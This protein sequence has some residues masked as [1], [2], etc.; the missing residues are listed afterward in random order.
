MSVVKS[1]SGGTFVPGTGI[2]A[3]CPRNTYSFP[4]GLRLSCQLPTLLVSWLLSP[5]CSNVTYMWSVPWPLSYIENNDSQ[6][7]TAITQGPSYPRILLYFLYFTYHRL[8]CYIS[9]HLFT[10][11][12]SPLLGYKLYKNR[13]LVL[14]PA[15]S[16]APRTESGKKWERNIYWRHCLEECNLKGGKCRVLE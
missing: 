6:P 10:Y 15:V 13:N 4:L 5:F 3:L 11:F 12:L 1:A 16:L 14:F 8:T 2:R 7:L 9:A